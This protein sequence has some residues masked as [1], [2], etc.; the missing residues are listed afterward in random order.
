MKRVSFFSEEGQGLAEYGLLLTAVALTAVGILSLLG[1][2]VGDVI[3]QAV[4]GL[5]ADGVCDSSIFSDDFSQGM[6]KWRSWYNRPNNWTISDEEDPQLCHVGK[7]GDFLLAENSDGN[8]Y[9][10][11]TNANIDS[12]NGYG[13]FFRATENENGRLDGYTLQYDPG[14]GGGEFIMRKWV[15]GYELSPPFARA[16]PPSGFQWHDV[17]R[18][19]EIEVEGDTFVTYVDGEQVLVA[20]DDSYPEGGAGLRTW[21][22]SQVC[23][24]DFTVTSR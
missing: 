24:D 21:S 1:V 17:D 12:G 15:N 6:D 23:F 2:R 7:G 3:C 11:S 14:Y 18:Q 4:E 16:K 9:T 8:D 19:I 22:S 20:Q 5:G 10:V 13:V